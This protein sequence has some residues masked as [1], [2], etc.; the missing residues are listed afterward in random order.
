MV[1]GSDGNSLVPP[2]GVPLQLAT[3]GGFGFL[4]IRGL[5]RHGTLLCTLWGI[6][7]I[8]DE[9][10]VPYGAALQRDIQGNFCN[11]PSLSVVLKMITE[12]YPHL[13]LLRPARPPPMTGFTYLLRR[14]EGNVLFTTKASVQEDLGALDAFGGVQHLLLGDR[15]HAL[16]ATAKL[17]KR[18]GTVL[19]ASTIEAE[20][21][22]TKGIEI[23]R[24]FEYRRQT[25]ATDLELLPTPGHTRGAFSYLWTR[26]TRRFLFIGDTLVP[27]DGDWRY[28]VTKPNLRAF[29]E[30]LG[31]LR[32]LKFDVIL[33][34]SFAATPAAWLEV[35]PRARQRLFDAVELDLPTLA[36]QQLLAENLFVA[37]NSEIVGD[38]QSPDRRVRCFNRFKEIFPR[39]GAPILVIEGCAGCMKMGVPTMPQR[40]LFA[41]QFEYSTHN[42][43]LGEK[44]RS[45]ICPSTRIS[46]GSAKQDTTPQ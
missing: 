21:L 10:E 35:D 22:E 5:G 38:T 23:G 40:S 3:R 37:F 20:V 36:G 15:H 13:F 45:R 32:G 43:G 14:D 8:T 4:K 28:R 17:A 19:S 2:R 26:G 24:Q 11:L 9:L 6:S 25:L 34:N 31:L 39:V 46:R 44:V 27:V 41:F 7:C 42:A 12:I 16:P 1:V 33:S 29:R 18:F 30:T